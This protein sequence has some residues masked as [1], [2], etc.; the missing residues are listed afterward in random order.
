MERTS[1]QGLALVEKYYS[2]YGCRAKE[3]KKEGKKSM[4]YISAAAPVE[5]I[6]AAGFTPVR[7][8][9]DP[10]EAVT[11]AYGRMETLVCPFV[12]SAFDLTL[13]GKYDY[14]DGIVIPHTCDSVSRT[15]EVWKRNVPLPYY[16]FLNVPH[17]AVRSFDLAFSLR[18]KGIDNIYP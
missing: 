9:G 14:L 5:I 11:K 15:Y 18:G 6:N 8:K 10:R 12:L 17:L 7:I 13:K 4:G 1:S 3:L 16:H 2:D